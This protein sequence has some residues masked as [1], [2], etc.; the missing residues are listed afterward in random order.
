MSHVA[1][2]WIDKK[3]TSPIVGGSSVERL[4]EILDAC[5]KALTDE[6]DRYLEELYQPKVIIEHT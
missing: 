4:E 2:D 5:G 6:E 1:L 3:V